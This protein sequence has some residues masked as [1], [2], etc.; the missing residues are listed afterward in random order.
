MGVKILLAD[1]SPTVHKVIK[2]ILANEPFVVLECAREADLEKGLAQAPGLV[3]LDFNFSETQTGYDLCRQI[4]SKLPSSEVLMMYGT[5]DTVDEGLLREAGCTQHVVKPFDTS[6]FIYQ[7]RAMAEK[8]NGGEVHVPKLSEQKRAAS[9]RPTTAPAAIPADEWE[10]GVPGVIGRDSGPELP[11]VISTPSVAAPTP[12]VPKK[13]LASEEREKLPAAEDLEYPDVSDTR[14]ELPSSAPAAATRSK[15]VPLNELAPLEMDNTPGT[16][17]LDT[18]SDDGAKLIEEQIQDEIG[19][20]LWSVDT[21]EEARPRFAEPEPVQPERTSPGFS[22]EDDL[23]FAPFHQVE[24][25]PATSSLDMDNLRP[26]IKQLVEEAVKEY[27]R[28][29]VD[30]VAWEVI[31]DLAENLIKKELQQ[32]S[33]KITRDL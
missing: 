19:A 28:T 10:V 1:D 17:E 27:C 30:K 15:L 8:A 4:K 11:P 6:R 9:P 12:V 20:D 25:T 18:R 16:L 13:A 26:L 5:F 31:P 23:D 14:P 22:L 32:I 3:F 24:S 21:F 33:A 2:I 29:H 7:V